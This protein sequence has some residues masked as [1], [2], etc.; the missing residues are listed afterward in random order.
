MSHTT[1]TPVVGDAVSLLITNP[2]HLETELETAVHT[3]RPS[4]A[5]LNC[6][7]LVVRHGPG[8]YTAQFARDVP[9]GLTREHTTWDRTLSAAFSNGQILP[10]TSGTVGGSPATRNVVVA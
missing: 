7:I 10:E 5:A 8:Q 9:F 1:H 2:A 3:L 6:G 4:A